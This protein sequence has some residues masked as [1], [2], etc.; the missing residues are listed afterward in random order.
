MADRMDVCKTLARK[1]ASQ[2]REGAG[3]RGLLYRDDLR[4]DVPAGAY[5]IHWLRGQKLE[6]AHAG[7]AP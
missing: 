4:G 1:K 7:E 2:R 6:P 5:K 3:L